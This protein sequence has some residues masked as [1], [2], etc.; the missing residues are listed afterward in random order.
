MDFV[1]EAKKRIVSASSTYQIYKILS[2]IILIWQIN[3]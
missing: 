3:R 1:F 2:L